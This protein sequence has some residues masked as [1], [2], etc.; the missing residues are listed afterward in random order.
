MFA[1]AFIALLLAISSGVLVT[2]TSDVLARQ[3]LNPPT[4]YGQQMVRWHQSAMAA[5]GANPVIVANP[6]DVQVLDPA[7]ILP[8]Y[9]PGGVNNNLWFSVA[10]NRGGTRHTFTYSNVITLDANGEPQANFA[11]YL[12][13]DLV[14]ELERIMG[15][16]VQYGMLEDTGT[17]FTMDVFAYDP[18]SNGF[19]LSSNI[20]LSEVS[21][22]TL[23][24]PLEAGEAAI[25]DGGT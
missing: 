13:G 4:I 1:V 25:L 10:F 14:S 3:S 11:Q 18:A 22:I 15:R 6:G 19:A 16:S 21:G 7:L 20:D 2:V 9:G 12:G 5:V 24:P 17:A 23:T 8:L